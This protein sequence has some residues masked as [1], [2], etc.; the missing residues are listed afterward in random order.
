MISKVEREKRRHPSD[1]VLHDENKPEELVILRDICGVLCE[2]MQG[3]RVG[4]GKERVG[5]STREM[6][7]HSEG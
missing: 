5:G 2:N 1:S 7:Y 3:A 4:K 6:T